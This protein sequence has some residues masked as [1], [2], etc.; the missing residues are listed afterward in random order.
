VP[1]VKSFPIVFKG[2]KQKFRWQQLSLHS[3]QLPQ[4]GQG[5]CVA[6]VLHPQPPSAT[7]GCRYARRIGPQSPSHVPQVSQPQPPLC[8]NPQHPDVDNRIPNPRTASHFIPRI[9]L[10][11]FFVPILDL[12]LSPVSMVWNSARA[13][14][15]L[16]CRLTDECPCLPVVIGRKIR[17]IELTLASRKFGTKVQAFQA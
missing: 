8:M 5:E 6:H 14:P 1:T 4:D 13:A 12:E 16:L 3:P 17:K 15:A 11:S 9:V 10:Y 7:T 2:W